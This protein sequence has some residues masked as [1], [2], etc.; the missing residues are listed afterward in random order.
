[1]LEK[2]F[3]Y[4]G[5]T[6]TLD[7]A[8]DVN[9]MV[10]NL[11][12]EKVNQI[13]T[14]MV[15]DDGNALMK[16]LK[17]GDVDAYKLAGA[18]SSIYSKVSQNRSAVIAELDKAKSSYM[19]DVI[20]SQFVEDALAPEVITDKVLTITSSNKQALKEIEQLQ[21]R[22]DFNKIAKLIAYDI[23]L[24]GEYIMSTRIDDKIGLEDV[25]DDVDQATV[26]ALTKNDDVNGY[27]TL[28]RDNHNKM[29]GLE[30][31][32]PREFIK[33]S[34]GFNKIRIRLVDEI[35][36]DQ[37]KK[38]QLKNLPTHVR[39]GKSLIHTNLSK[40]KELELLEALVP[41]T[42]LAKLTQGSVIGVQMPVTSDITEMFKSTK[43]IEQLLNKRV[44][45]NTSTNEL[46]IEKILDQAARIKV[47]P[48]LGDKGTLQ[49]FDY[50]MDEPD[51]MLASIEE[52]RKTICSS[53]GIP[54]EIIFGGEGDSKG[55][56]LKRY[57]RYLRRLKNIQRAIADGIYQMVYIH[58]VAK[59][60]DFKPS[61]IKVDFRNKLIE[62]DSLDR[63]EFL[64]SL[65]GYVERLW[66]FFTEQLAKDANDED[67]GNVDRV[68]L[69]EFIAE[70]F[71]QAGV[72][73]VI[74][75]KGTP[76]KPAD[77]K[78]IEGV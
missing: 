15:D 64:D 16:I 63:L 77:G 71:T 37:S 4:F 68:K 69:L 65:T 62:I 57:A 2:L 39:I 49:K 13:K 40:I 22:I 33:F 35:S 36:F 26:I 52:L 58:L 7:N 61:D 56:L 25:V 53:A 5:Y 6:P 74:R 51:D 31:K 20:I 30:I 66:S 23:L 44:G 27:L 75:P 76:P 34:Y 29:M 67:S 41:A 11:V 55:E 48:V 12:S 28:G 70:Q 38:D 42:K 60:I 59:N 50:K 78:S 21:T 45:L 73:G 32:D 72:D 18:L 10:D 1:M 24:Y 43:K 3:E 17:G 14:L 54:Y 46:S 9:E 19:V 8:G 47:V